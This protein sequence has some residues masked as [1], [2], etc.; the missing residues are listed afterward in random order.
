VTGPGR[1]TLDR[2]TPRP[3]QPIA[4]AAVSVQPLFRAAWGGALLIAPRPALRLLGAG[5]VPDSG[6]VIARVL[7]ARHVL[8]AL[9]TRARPLRPVLIAGGVTD[10]LHS[11]S[12]VLLAVVQP[13]WRRP[14]LTDAALAAGFAATSWAGA[15]TKA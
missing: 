14:A 8:Q 10:A 4:A 12:D 15:R 2:L 13:R 5:H 6:L 3:A 9:I 1:A 7:G 11:A